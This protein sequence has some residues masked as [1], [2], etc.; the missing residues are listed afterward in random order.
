MQAKD[1]SKEAW[2]LSKQVQIP[3]LIGLLLNFAT[4]VWWGAKLEARVEQHE[5][6]LAAL[7]STDAAT[8]VEARRVAEL[9][10]RLD[11]RLSNQGDVLRRLDAALGRYNAVPP[12]RQ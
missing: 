1:E 12:S 6:Q 11:E 2:H 5:G 10:T 8:A 9:L 7:L 3:M 4:L